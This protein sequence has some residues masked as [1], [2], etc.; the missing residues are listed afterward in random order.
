[1]ITVYIIFGILI[2]IAIVLIIVCHNWATN[3]IHYS[4]SDEDYT[5]HNLKEIKNIIDIQKKNN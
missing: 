2:L 3:A 1:M 4:G 5:Y